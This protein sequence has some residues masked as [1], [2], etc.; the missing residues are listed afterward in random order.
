M[1][2]VAGIFRS[3]AAAEEAV[4]ALVNHGV[5]QASIVFLTA[6][7]PAAEI[8]SEK[9]LDTMPTT[10][11]EADGMG[12]TVGALMGGGVGAS[13]GWAAGEAIA[14]LLIPGVGPILAVGLGAAA[15]LGLGGAIAGAE[16][17]G[18]AEHAMDAGVPKDDVLVYRALLKQGRSLVIANV[19]DEKLARTAKHVMSERGGEDVEH[20][21]KQLHSAA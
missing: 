9:E 6:E 2:S 16:V 12:K 17:G 1:Q 18:S 19:N 3:R 11:A 13:A 7:S 14:S 15:L 21:R 5:P 20:V 10:D 8:R 4:N